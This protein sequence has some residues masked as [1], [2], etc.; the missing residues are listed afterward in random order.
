MRAKTRYH[1]KDKV[2]LHHSLVDSRV[3]FYFTCVRYDEEG[4]LGSVLEVGANSKRRKMAKYRYTIA[5]NAQHF[6]PYEELDIGR[7]D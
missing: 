1:N 4:I 2:T 5:D 3:S 7:E 6:A